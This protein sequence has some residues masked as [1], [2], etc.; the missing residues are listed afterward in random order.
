MRMVCV[1]LMFC[2]M[3]VGFSLEWLSLEGN[4]F[5]FLLETKSG[6]FSLIS[7]RTNY[8]YYEG[9]GY[10]PTSLIQIFHDNEWK[11]VGLYSGLLWEKPWMK[12]NSLL[13][14]RVRWGE[15]VYSFGFFLTNRGSGL[16]FVVAACHISNAS[17]E[18]TEVGF[19]YLLDT[20]LGEDGFSSL[21]WFENGASMN[22][23]T[24]IFVNIYGNYVV[25]GDEKKG[26]FIQPAYNGLSPRAIYLA[27]YHRLKT[28]ERDIRIEPGADFVYGMPGRRDGAVLVEYR[29]RLRPGESLE[30]G[31]VMGL[32]GFASLRW[33]QTLFDFSFDSPSTHML[34]VPQ[35]TNQKIP[36]RR[37]SSS[38]TNI[39]YLTNTISVSSGDMQYL[40]LQKALVEKLEQLFHMLT[41]S[42]SITSFSYAEN[43]NTMSGKGVVSS[44][45]KQ[46]GWF[47]N[48]DPFLSRRGTQVVTNI[49]AKNV[50]STSSD[51]TVPQSTKTASMPE[52]SSPL[53]LSSSSVSG[54]PEER[55]PVVFFVTN[56]ITNYVTVADDRT[57]SQAADALVKSYEERLQILQKQLL[58]LEKY[59]TVRETT[60]ARL[61][62]IEKRLELLNWLLERSAQ[63]SLKAEDIVRMNEEIEILLRDIG[64]ASP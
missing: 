54:K 47:P 14:G 59:T 4:L 21:F 17:S 1:L 18:A 41:N 38:L 33:N 27:N 32:E 5:S 48:E 35:E 16:P 8:L 57:K 45:R 64:G 34:L 62:L 22:T 39:V 9:K 36:S 25:S 30:G 63:V 43:T 46:P 37:P 29:Y 49:S 24:A 20:T 2:F 52:G 15:I 60:S 55:S 23:E 11:E 3:G 53:E 19:R 10:P 31:V 12:T 51:G 44:T 61:Y 42:S 40:L 56:V 28:A 6:H 50:G 26:F 13:Y 58:E 7:S